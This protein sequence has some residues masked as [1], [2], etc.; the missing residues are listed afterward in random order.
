MKKYLSLL[1]VCV[2][3]SSCFKEKPLTVAA[4]NIGTLFTAHMGP[5]YDTQLYFN[6]QNGVFVDSNNRYE[7]DL[8]FD[9]D[10]NK[11]NVWMNGSKLMLVAKTGKYN[12]DDVTANDTLTK[13]WRVEFGYGLSDSNAIGQWGNYPISNKEVYLL[14]LGVDEQGNGFGFKKL[15]IG[16]YNG[17]YQITYANLDGTESVNAFIPKNGDVNFTY[18]SFTSRSIKNLEPTKDIWDIQFTVYSTYFYKEKLPYKVTGVLTN[19]SRTQTYLLDSTSDFSKIT[20]Q[21][22]DNSK[23]NAR[24]DGIGYEWKRYEYNSYIINTGYNFIVKSENKYYKLRMLDFYDG[25]GNKGYP[26]FEYEE[27]K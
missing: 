7:Y 14:N 22:V 15:Q 26:K 4:P 12:L 16:D 11:F 27:L 3:L 10:A 18:Y 5:D 25:N 2:C 1:V 17:G 24:R 6:M 13:T 20:I 8:A 21:A 19:P 9:C 23:F